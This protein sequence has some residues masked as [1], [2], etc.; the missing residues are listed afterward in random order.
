MHAPAGGVGS[1]CDWNVYTDFLNDIRRALNAARAD[2]AVSDE[3]TVSACLG[4][5]NIISWVN[6]KRFEGDWV[7]LMSYS[8]SSY[9]N[10]SVAEYRSQGATA[11][12][13]GLPKSKINIGLGTYLLR[14]IYVIYCHRFTPVFGVKL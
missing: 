8:G 11:E 13:V 1:S 10:A 4:N 14:V 3:K 2:Q 9:D 12:R 6:P 5:Y 7:S